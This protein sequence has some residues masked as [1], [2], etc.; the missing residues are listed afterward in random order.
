MLCAPCRARKASS[1]T[2]GAGGG[3]SAAVTGCAAW[4]PLL[5]LVVRALRLL[6]TVDVCASTQEVRVTLKHTQAAPLPQ[7]NHP[8]SCV[9]TQMAYEC[10]VVVGLAVTGVYE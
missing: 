5:P 9:R 4:G 8:P 3:G 1:A 7:P 10:W 2:G 6:R